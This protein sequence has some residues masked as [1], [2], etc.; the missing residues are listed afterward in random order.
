MLTG[1]HNHT[2]GQYGLQHGPYNF[3]TF[4][5]LKSLPVLLSEAG[6][7]T[8]SI[9]KIHVAPEAVYQF[10][11]TI[12]HKTPGG[13][14]NPVGMANDAKGFLAEASD[15]PFFLYFC[16]TDPHRAGEG[17]ANLPVRPGVEPVVYDPAT[18]PVP[19][20]LPDT[21][22][23][24]A[25]WADF[26]QAVSRFDQGVGRLLE[27]L[28][29]TGHADDT[30]VIAVSDNGPP[31]PGAKTTLYEP[32]IRLPLIVR[33]PGHPS[34]GT[35]CQAM[36][37][38]VDLAPTILDFA[39]AEGPKYP[40]HGRSFLPLL[41][42]ET[43]D[44][45]D[46]IFASHTFHEV[47]MYYPMRALRDGRYKLIFNI[48]HPLP[49]PFA[50]DLYESTTWQGVLER[51]D[52]RYGPRTVAAYLHRPRFELYDLEA[53]PLEARNLA[54]DPAQADRLAAM[55]A[56]LRAFQEKTG[57]PWALKWDRE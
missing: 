15:R 41:G 50:S 48:A 27:V 44:G 10:G 56:R 35:A 6:Y 57:D 40:L 55:K 18:L 31:F 37:S 1:L 3:Q 28:E 47:Q 30:L 24:R 51:G 2:N 46:H 39:G 20:Y 8:A 19:P 49:F 42:Q 38:F 14:H 4:A 17:F 52:E 12:P 9:G 5:R 53:D 11:Q 29:E 43:A 25:E 23:A 7:R 16:P 33:A 32:G 36:V 34:P 26:A 22:E 54:D 45:W 21:P 13:A